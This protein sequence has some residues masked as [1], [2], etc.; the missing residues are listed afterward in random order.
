MYRR[1]RI[2]I[3]SR[4]TPVSIFSETDYRAG[5]VIPR[6]GDRAEEKESSISM[7]ETPVY[8]GVLGLDFAISTVSRERGNPSRPRAPSQEWKKVSISRR[9]FAEKKISGRLAHYAKRS[10]PDHSGRA[11]TLYF[12]VGLLMI[13]DQRRESPLFARS[14]ASFRQLSAF[15]Y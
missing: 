14:R 2:L 11:F 7:M 4:S 1:D 10:L 13:A 3:F 6:R 5:R 9:T 15:P 12:A 8:G